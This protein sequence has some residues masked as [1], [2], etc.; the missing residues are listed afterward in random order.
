MIQD[1]ALTCY[2]S[3]YVSSSLLTTY[4]MSLYTYIYA[5]VSLTSV[6]LVAVLAQDLLDSLDFRS[7]FIFVLSKMFIELPVGDKCCFNLVF[8]KYFSCCSAVPLIKCVE[9][10][11]VGFSTAFSDLGFLCRV[12]F[13]ITVSSKYFFQ[14]IHFVFTGCRYL[15]AFVIMWSAFGVDLW[16]SAV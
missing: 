10:F 11:A 5:P 13:R 8:L 4:L 6:S 15:L 2:F 14:Y 12:V 7:V 16:K 3:E 1:V 9:D